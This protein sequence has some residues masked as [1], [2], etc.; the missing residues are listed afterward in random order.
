[1]DR[2][3]AC[4]VLAHGSGTGVHEGAASSLSRHYA[5]HYSVV[6]STPMDDDE[7]CLFTFTSF[8]RSVCMPDGLQCTHTFFCPLLPIRLY[9]SCGNL[10]SRSG[11]DAS[12]YAGLLSLRPLVEKKPH[13][14]FCSLMFSHRSRSV[15][16]LFFLSKGVRFLNTNFV[17]TGTPFDSFVILENRLSILVYFLSISILG[18]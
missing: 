2:S 3:G 16:S 14:S 18:K 4:A 7:S 12:A 1:M 11:L 8:A 15:L 17:L 9:T 5:S 10:H 6:C 13:R